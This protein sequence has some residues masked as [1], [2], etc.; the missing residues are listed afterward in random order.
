[1][2]WEMKFN[3]ETILAYIDGQ[4]SEAEEEK[5]LIAMNEDKEIKGLFEHY[6]GIHD[7]LEESKLSSPSAGFADRVME[8]V[9]QLHTTRTKFFNRSRLFVISLITIILITS[10]YYLSIQFYPTLGDTVANTVSMREYTFNLNAVKSFLNSDVIFKMVFYVN[11]VIGLFL[12]DRAVLKPF[13]ARRRE[14]YSM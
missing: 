13:F 9:Y 3:E 14:R 6:K 1:M 12:F 8:T 10:A 11:G 5:F 7:S 2:N 4:L